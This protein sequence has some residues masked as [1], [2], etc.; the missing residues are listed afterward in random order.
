MTPACAASQSAYAAV[1]VHRRRFATD[2]P[3]PAAGPAHQPGPIIPAS[4]AVAPEAADLRRSQRCDTGSNPEGSAIRTKALLLAGLWST[5]SNGGKNRQ[6]RGNHNYEAIENRTTRVGCSCCR[7]MLA[8]TD[9]CFQSTSDSQTSYFRW[10]HCFGMSR[11]EHDW[12]NHVNMRAE[13]FR[14]Y[15]VCGHVHNEHPSDFDAY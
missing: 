8:T 6:I 12:R 5:L 4:S 15:R 9:S 1:A 13:V 10:R 7:C 14:W 11:D 2:G 3:G